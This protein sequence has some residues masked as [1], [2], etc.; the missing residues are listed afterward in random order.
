MTGNNKVWRASL[1]GLASVAMLATMGVVAGTAN[2][3]TTPDVADPKV[4]FVYNGKTYG[5]Q[6]VT[7]G[8]SLVDALAG[9]VKTPSDADIVAS[10]SAAPSGKF[11]GYYGEDGQPFDFTAPLTANTKVVAKYADD[12]DVVAVTFEGDYGFYPLGD[13][14]GYVLKGST[15]DARQAPTD[16]ADGQLTTAWSVEG[17]GVDTT[18][19]A[20]GTVD[21]LDKIAVTR[22]KD[23]AATV[24]VKAKEFAS[25]VKTLRFN[26]KSGTGLASTSYALNAYA[27]G[28]NDDDLL[29]D[30]T[31]N[32]YAAPTII[33][34]TADPTDSTKDKV[35]FGAWI[36]EPGTKH[37][38]K[39]GEDIA[40]VKDGDTFEIDEASVVKY[41]VVKFDSKGGTSVAGERVLMDQGNGTYGFAKEPTAPTKD[42]YVFKGWANPSGKIIDWT[43]SSDADNSPRVNYT[44]SAITLTA[45]WQATTSELKVTFRDADYDGKNADVA[46]KVN[47]N[48]FLSEDQA[49]SWTR[50]GYVLKGWTY[51]GNDFDFDAQVASDVNSGNDFVLTPVWIKVEADIVPAA[52]KYVPAESNKYTTGLNVDGYKALFTADSWK[53]YSAAYTN[54]RKEYDQAVFASQDGKA[55]AET[56]AKLVSEL[57]DAWEKLVFEHNGGQ[58]VTLDGTA[59]HR[60]FSP[61]QGEHFY[62]ADPAEILMLTQ[63]LT[64]D[65]G[66]ND[67]GVLFYTAK[68]G[69]Q[70]ADALASFTEDTKALK[71]VVT[72][73][74]TD[75]V[76]FF[77]PSTGDHVWTVEGGDE[78]NALKPQDSWNEEGAAFY[79]PTFTGTTKVNRLYNGELN[80]HLL[81]VSASEQATLQGTGWT[82]EGLAVKGI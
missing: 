68:K 10:G 20:D 56:A 27:D 62:S 37:S 60:L 71:D 70:Y 41:V 43:A 1:A 18:K 3:A 79:A 39:V 77:N 21:A 78:Y 46:V 7:Y 31:A 49:P 55:S 53:T 40:N 4:T 26:G 69:D 61:T 28:A 50:D 6:E 19:I 58:D 65:G 2:A 73:I 64:T 12:V 44:K 47:G 67:E 13:A 48:D 22:P 82:V 51:N 11:I 14:T 59:V 29:V 33:T 63:K 57:K 36:N 38:T 5:T 24:T 9:I 32:S 54:V 35:T 80:R 52:L 75:Y 15:L 74:L 76:R 45:Q 16:K 8:D 72:P 17:A 42:G 81:S 66:W 34:P 30:T 23:G 25:D